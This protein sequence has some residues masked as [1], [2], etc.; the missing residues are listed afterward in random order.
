MILLIDRTGSDRFERQGME[1]CYY[2]TDDF[3]LRCPGNYRRIQLPFTMIGANPLNNP[4]WLILGGSIE[5]AYP[6]KDHRD[7]EKWSRM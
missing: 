6:L 3:D 5:S 1:F 7:R 4:V 2:W